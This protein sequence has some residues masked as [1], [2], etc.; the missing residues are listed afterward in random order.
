MKSKSQQWGRGKESN[1][2]LIAILYYL[3]NNKNYKLQMQNAKY[4]TIKNKSATY[5]Q[6]EN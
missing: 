3:K 2:S 1:R 6:V 4:K 5:G